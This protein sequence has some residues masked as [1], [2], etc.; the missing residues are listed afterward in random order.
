MMQ[1]HSVAGRVVTTKLIGFIVGG[2]AFFGLPALGAELS[3]TFL[4][5][6]W[7]FYMLMSVNIG[8]M[9]IFTKHPILG[10]R[11]YYWLRGPLLG[12]AYHLMLV[13][14]AYNEIA[15]IMTLP[16]FAW[17]GLS[18]PFWILIDGAILGLIIAWVATKFVGEGNLPI[19]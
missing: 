19:S 3:L 17:F 6:L 8:L 15:S 13:L 10:F 9:G 12:T 18:S 4:L 11:M 1:Q 7:A 2:I 14:L 5:G 16:A